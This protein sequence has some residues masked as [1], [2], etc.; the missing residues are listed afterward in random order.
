MLALYKQL[1]DSGYDAVDIMAIKD[2]YEHLEKATDRCRRAGDVVAHI[3][4]KNAWRGAGRLRK[5][6]RL[7]GYF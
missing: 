4:L 6:Q 5:S 7:F 1:L 3:A 2:L